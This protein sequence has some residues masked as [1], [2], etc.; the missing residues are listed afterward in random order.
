ME[1]PCVR[2]LVYHGVV[3]LDQGEPSFSTV[4]SEHAVHSGLGIS[5]EDGANAIGGLGAAP[6]FTVFWTAKTDDASSSS[7]IGV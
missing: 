6:I 5:V 7:W 1:R 2:R 4:Y 3:G